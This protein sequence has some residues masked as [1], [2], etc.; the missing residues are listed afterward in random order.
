MTS[1]QEDKDDFRG[2][3]RNSHLYTS[4]VHLAPDVM[5][6]FLPILHG[7]PQHLTRSI[8]PNLLSTHCLNHLSVHAELNVSKQHIRLYTYT[9]LMIIISLWF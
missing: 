1:L 6:K 5:H 9:M 8:K 7:F 4:L 2:F 3:H